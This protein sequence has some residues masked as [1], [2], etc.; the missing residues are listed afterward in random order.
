MTH[1]GSEFGL[2]ASVF[3][4][5]LRAGL[6]RRLSAG[7]AWPIGQ[8]PPTWAEQAPGTSTSLLLP[9]F[10]SVALRNIV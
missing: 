9:Y 6:A 5:L 3:E 8:G 10:Q 7:S 2:G 4:T 1:Y